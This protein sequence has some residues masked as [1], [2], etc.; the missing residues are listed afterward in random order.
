MRQVLFH[1]LDKIEITGMQSAISRLQGEFIFLLFLPKLATN[2]KERNEFFF[3]SF[4]L[5][6]RTLRDNFPKNIHAVLILI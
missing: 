3:A 5:S 2:R 6:W 4:A 1:K